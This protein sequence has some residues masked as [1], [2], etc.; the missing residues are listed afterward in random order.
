MVE[1]SGI[2]TNISNKLARTIFHETIHEVSSRVRRNKRERLMRN[3]LNPEMT[4]N[5]ARPAN[6]HGIAYND[7]HFPD[8]NNYDQNSRTS[9]RQVKARKITRV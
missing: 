6:E 9:L 7:K 5:Y 3:K 1:I 8:S 4:E 2:S